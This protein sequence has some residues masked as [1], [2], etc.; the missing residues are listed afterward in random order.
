MGDPFSFAR[1]IVIVYV[2]LNKCD[3]NKLIVYYIFIALIFRF[4]FSRHSNFICD[5]LLFKIL[6]EYDCTFQK[7][8][9][10]VLYIIVGCEFILIKLCFYFSKYIVLM[11]T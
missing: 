7:Y 4:G 6:S 2:E 11:T 8:Y 9:L 10:R 3:L 5:H 1:I